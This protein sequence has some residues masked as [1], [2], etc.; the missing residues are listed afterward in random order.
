MKAGTSPTGV[1]RRGGQ[2]RQP[3]V[4]TECRF[5]VE[6]G[7]KAAVGLVWNISHGGVS[8]LVSRPYPPGTELTG[9]LI[10]VSQ[11][12]RLPIVLR[13][14]HLTRLLTGDYCVGGPFLRELRDDELQPFLAV[15]AAK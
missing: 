15:P 14:S 2:R 4:G 11:S 1:E 13:V 7:A 12:A 6:E 9:E 3:A 8:L 5:V 10:T